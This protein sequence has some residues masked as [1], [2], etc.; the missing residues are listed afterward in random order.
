MKKLVFF[1]IISIFASCNRTGHFKVEGTIEGGAGEMIYLEHNGLTKS[2]ILDSTRV[3]DDG[4]FRFRAKSPV[5]PDFYK[6]KVGSKQIHFAVDSTETIGIT[7]SFDNFSTEYTITGSESNTDIQLLRKS[8]AEIQRKANQI[9]RGMN[10]T[11]REKLVSELLELIEKHK[12]SARPIILKNPRSTAA[13]FAVFQKINDTFIFSPYVKEDRPYCAAVATSYNT[14]MPDY[15][16][17]KNL[18]ALVMDAIK[19]E[20]QARQQANWREIVESAATGYIDIEL[21]DKNNH[22]RKLSDLTGKVILLDFSAFE[23][24]ESVQYTFALRELHNKYASRGF[25]I[26][27]VSLDRNKLLWEDAV[28][29]LPWVCVRDANGPNTVYAATYN[30]TSIPSYFLIDRQGDIVG[31]D[32]NLQTLEKE[33]EKRL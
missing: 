22:N 32:M 3:K 2:I 23:S 10:D 19:T 18:Y 26:Y 1:L 28:Q 21:P 14:Y 9:I 20:R 29:N 12:V 8:A 17:T 7:A 15:D 4:K 30:I 6:L 11:E 5:Y 33:I 25:E 27:Q 24:R 13:Y 16:R 31:R